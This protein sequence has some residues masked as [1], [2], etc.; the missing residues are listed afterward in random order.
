M[1]KLRERLTFAN[2]VSVIALI[3]A[4]GLGGAWAA[5]ELSGFYASYRD[6]F[7]AE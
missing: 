2:V 1:G 7:A 5:T 6:V 3:F 4:M